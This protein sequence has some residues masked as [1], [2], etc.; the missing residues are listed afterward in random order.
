MMLGDVMARLTDDGTAEEIVLALGDLGLL[1]ALRERAAAEGVG[2]A[3]LTR[4][5]VR[6]YAAEASDEEW[7][8]LMGLMGR[9]SDPG[10]ACLQRA[11][12]NALRR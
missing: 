1:A 9:A 12:D 7:I 8:T 11:F 5:A 10:L 6:C 3:T 4:D 2:L